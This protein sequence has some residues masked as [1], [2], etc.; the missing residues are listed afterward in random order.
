MMSLAQMA[1]AV[2]HTADGRAK[3][4]LSRDFAA[5]WFTARAAGDAVVIGTATPPDMPARPDRP[6]LC[7]PRDVPRRKTGSNE[8]RNALLH[9]VAHIELNDVD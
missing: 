2:L 1:C 9:A 6:E 3:T 7:A 4:A 8:G 5:Q